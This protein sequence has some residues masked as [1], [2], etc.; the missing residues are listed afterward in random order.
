MKS[1]ACKV[2]VNGFSYEDELVYKL[3]SHEFEFIIDHTQSTI[4]TTNDSFLR[5][6]NRI[7]NATD[8]RC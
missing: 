1:C 5:G 7:A 3:L 8:W 4:N 2:R 6:L